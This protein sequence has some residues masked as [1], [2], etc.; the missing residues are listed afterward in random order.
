MGVSSL[1]EAINSILVKKS[2]TGQE[3]EWRAPGTSFY[4]PGT[5]SSKSTP[6]STVTSP[7]GS[8]KSSRKNSN[9]R[10]EAQLSISKG[11]S[12]YMYSKLHVG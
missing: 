12:R 6:S 2:S 4:F 1:R 7:S 8:N 3:L 5:S 10:E 9:V 11:Q